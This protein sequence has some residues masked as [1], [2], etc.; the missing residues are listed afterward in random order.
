MDYDIP[1]GIGITNQSVANQAINA[2]TTALLAGSTLPVPL[3]KLR[4]RSVIRWTL[5]L[6][7]TAAGTLGVAYLVKIGLAGTV[8][9]A[10]ILSFV[11][12]VGTAAVDTGRID[13]VVTIRGPLTASCIAQ[14]NFRLSHNLSTTGLANVPTVVLNTTSAGFNATTDN[15]I[16]SLACT[17]PAST[18]LTFQ[19]VIAEGYN[20]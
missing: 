10:T 12:P 6:S 5:A 16:L 3:S 9:D 7:K 2:S 20:L 14:G 1:A 15:L 18:V 17:T 8:A 11:T 4:I 13:I 19:Q